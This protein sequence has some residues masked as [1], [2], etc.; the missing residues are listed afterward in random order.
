MELVA[1]G[2]VCRGKR[3]VQAESS[4]FIS[5]FFVTGETEA[6]LRG[7]Q[8]ALVRRLMGKV[9]GVAGLS[10][11]GLMA[12]AAAGVHCL[13]VTGQTE[14]LLVMFELEFL[15]R[16]M[17]IMTCEALSVKHRLMLAVHLWRLLFVSCVVFTGRPCIMTVQAYLFGWFD[18]KQALITCMD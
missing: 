2:A 12:G 10:G 7:D 16:G 17:A 8:K 3:L 14:F 1:S 18:Q 9:A 6:V 15:L 11:G 13:I 5:L 4:P